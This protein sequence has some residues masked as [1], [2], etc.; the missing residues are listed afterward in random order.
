[1]TI[2][3]WKYVQTSTWACDRFIDKNCKR[4]EWKG[5]FYCHV[6]WG[7]WPCQHWTPFQLHLGAFVTAY[8]SIYSGGPYFTNI[9]NNVTFFISAYSCAKVNFRLLNI[10]LLRLKAKSLYCTSRVKFLSSNDA[11]KILYT[12]T[13]VRTFHPV[14]LAHQRMHT[15]NSATWPWYEG[16]RS[17]TFHCEMCGHG[18]RCRLMEVNRVNRSFYMSLNDMV[19]YW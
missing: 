8:K 3:L 16:Q 18:D 5:W 17:T 9:I 11:G 6:F 1:M 15:G 12:T 19:H 4:L 7:R 10:Y 2:Q 13:Q 14:A